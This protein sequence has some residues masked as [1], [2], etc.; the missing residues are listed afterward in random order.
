MDV[1]GYADH[2]AGNS[3]PL[4]RRSGGRS[5]CSSDAL[6]GVVAL[7]APQCPS[8]L[9]PLSPLSPLSDAS[10][11]P[12]ATWGH[13]AHHTPSTRQLPRDLEPGEGIAATTTHSCGSAAQQPGRCGSRPGALCPGQ[14]PTGG[15]ARSQKQPHSAAQRSRSPA[16]LPKRW[17]N[18]LA[19]A[20]TYGRGAA[21]RT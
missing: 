10:S 6:A 8:R 2:C 4:G 12:V 3:Q 5:I 13:T 7:V 1:H 15:V 21:M 19:D 20:T 11:E 18:H 9:S 14:I 16:A 17:G